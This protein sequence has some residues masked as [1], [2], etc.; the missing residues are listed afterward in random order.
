MLKSKKRSALFALTGFNTT[1]TKVRAS[2]GLFVLK[3]TKEFVMTCLFCEGAPS[4]AELE[5][6]YIR[7][8][9]AWM[10]KSC[11]EY[12][13]KQGSLEPLC[14]VCRQTDDNCEC[15]IRQIAAA[16]A[17]P[18][19][20]ELVQVLVSCEWG[21]PQCICAICTS[22]CGRIDKS[23][24]CQECEHCQALD[25]HEDYEVECAYCGQRSMN[26]LERCPHCDGC[27]QEDEAEPAYEDTALGRAFAQL[28]KEETEGPFLCHYCCDN[29]AP[30]RYGFCSVCEPDPNEAAFDRK[31]FS[32]VDCCNRVDE[33]D[34]E[35]FCLD[36]RSELENSYRCDT[37]AGDKDFDSIIEG[38]YSDVVVCDDC[39]E[40]L[41]EAIQDANVGH[42]ARC[43]DYG[44][45][46]ANWQVG[47]ICNSCNNRGEL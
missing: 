29:Y 25:E 38:L 36:C 4:T 42:C 26:S 30:T 13:E 46:V 41:R 31:P 6:I 37:C 47:A 2:F 12:L 7:N 18:N 1:A 35:G 8:F 20:G 24:A 16:E 27:F 17:S 23:V 14:S 21:Q 22:E 11:I 28:I 33:I 5:Q 9:P 39:A 3:T 45:R 15:Q 34:E 32:C 40:W 10:C 43:G 44:P 19:Y